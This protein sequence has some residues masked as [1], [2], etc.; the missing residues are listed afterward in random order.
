MIAPKSMNGRD[1]GRRNKTESPEIQKREEQ[2]IERQITKSS[3]IFNHFIYYQSFLSQIDYILGILYHR[4]RKVATGRADMS[5]NN[6]NWKLSS[7][8]LRLNDDL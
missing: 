4:F 5:S 3:V 1:V 6:N 8:W 7:E 2:S